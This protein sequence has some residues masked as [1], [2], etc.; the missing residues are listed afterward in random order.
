VAN[1]DCQSST[2]CGSSCEGWR[3]VLATE[4]LIFRGF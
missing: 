4:L 1:Q 2:G 3:G